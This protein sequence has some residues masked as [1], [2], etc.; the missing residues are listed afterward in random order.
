MLRHYWSSIHIATPLR[1]RSSLLA[2][3]HYAIGGRVLLRL[4]LPLRIIRLSLEILVTTPLRYVAGYHIGYWPL[5]I[6]LLHGYT[7]SLR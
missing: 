5:I 7:L 3:Y 1:R 4:L 2:E 6:S